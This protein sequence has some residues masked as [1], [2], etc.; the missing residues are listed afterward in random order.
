MQDAEKIKDYSDIKFF[1]SIKECGLEETLALYSKY[2]AGDFEQSARFFSS[3]KL[4]EKESIDSNVIAIYYPQLSGGGIENVMVKQVGM[5]RKLGY[6]PHFILEKAPEQSLIEAIGIN[7][8]I[9]PKGS[10]RD[11]KERAKEFSNILK[12]INA[13]IVIYHAWLNYLLPWDLLLC[14]LLNVRFVLHVHGIYTDEMHRLIQ[15]F[16]SRVC[17]LR[18][19]DAIVSLNEADA[20][21]WRQVNNRVFVVRNQLGMSCGNIHPAKTIN[22]KTI[23]W[24]GRIA[25]MKRPLDMVKAFKLVHDKC[26][27]AR[28]LMGGFGNGKLDVQ[29]KEEIKKLGLCEAVETVEW[30][31]DVSDL[32]NQARVFCLTSHSMEGFSLVLL[33]S[34][35]YGLPCVC[36]DLSYLTLVSEGNGILTA[37][38]GNIEKLANELLFVLNDDEFCLK[39]SNEARQAAENNEKYDASNTWSEIL[40]QSKEDFSPKKDKID[41]SAQVFI[42]AYIDAVNCLKSS[43]KLLAESDKKVEI[44]NDRVKKQSKQIKDLRNKQKKSAEENKKLRKKFEK[45]KNSRSYKFG[46]IITCV[47][48]KIVNISKRTGWHKR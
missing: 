43:R 11:Y 30:K 10:E 21:F 29:V 47:P 32:Y 33:E 2:Y 19:A 15:K 31:D 28:L 46:R 23:L 42:E 26:P 20:I 3:L 8:S 5:F 24:L 34:L 13:C 6:K 12:K 38:I 4:Q 1:E 16:V 39:L 14:K 45:I 41:S 25:N 35:A 9:I 44:L 17:A 36:Y 37:P 40:R 27:E 18:L 22:S 48:R 7:Y